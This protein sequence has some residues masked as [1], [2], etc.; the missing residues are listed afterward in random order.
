MA[1]ILPLLRSKFPKLVSK[2]NRRSLLA[3]QVAFC[4]GHSQERSA[5]EGRALQ[6]VFAEADG[7]SKRSFASEVS[8]RR[9]R[10]FQSR[11]YEYYDPEVSA[12]ARVRSKLEVRERCSAI[13]DRYSVHDGHDSGNSSLD[14]DCF[15]EMRAEIVWLACMCIHLLDETHSHSCN[16]KISKWNESCSGLTRSST[17]IGSARGSI[18]VTIAVTESDQDKRCSHSF[19]S[20]IVNRTRCVLTSRQ[21]VEIPHS[22]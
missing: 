13:S 15:G 6:C 3:R 4:S 14:R 20:T 9:P 17:G 22:R 21:M 7:D 8:Y 5:R 12:T 10:T 11:I 2:E 16:D 19:I 18:N 1:L